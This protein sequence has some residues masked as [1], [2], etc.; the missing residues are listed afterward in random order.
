MTQS[1]KITEE[2]RESFVRENPPDFPLYTTQLL[3]LANQN[4][5]STRRS[6]VGPMTEL[7]E[8]FHERHPKGTYEDWTQ[9]YLNEYDG[10]ERISEGTEELLEMLEKMR[11]AMEEID[12]DLAESYIRELVLYKTYQGTSR[13]VKEVVLKKL[14]ETYR[15]DYD[16]SE[17]SDIDGYI[18]DI[19]LEIIH[20][21]EGESQSNK[22]IVSVYVKGYR[23]SKNLEVDAEELSKEL[24][25]SVVDGELIHRLDARNDA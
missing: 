9:F 4:A 23:S 18:G 15:E 7:V 5:K 10:D 24:G 19:P 22:D 16:I 8:K 2:E 11:E 3:N 12:D 6:I 14:A 13:D 20:L 1:I 17:K 21:D 25:V